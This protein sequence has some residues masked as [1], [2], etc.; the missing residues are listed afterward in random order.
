MADL[1]GSQ[2]TRHAL[3][4]RV[5]EFSQ[6]GGIMP[7]VHDAGRSRGVR[8]L[9]VR[10]GTGFECE[11]V[12]DRALDVCD[13]S[14]R[15]I[16]LAWH[17]PGGL[18]APSYD[19]APSSNFAR[20]FFGGLMTTCGLTAFG[21]AG[22]DADGAWGQHGYID[23]AP[24]E[25]VS[26][27]ASWDGDRCTLEITGT[28][29]ETQLFGPYLRLDRTWRIELGGNVLQLQDRVTNEGGRRVPHMLLY[30]CN[31]G[32]PIV[33]PDTVVQIAQ[34]SMRARDDRA[35]RGLAVWDRGGEPEAQFAEQVFIHDPLPNE[36]GW[37]YA[38]I[39]NPS[40]GKNGM[41]FEVR[42]RP[43]DL[44][45]VFSWRMLAEK[46]YV[47]AVEPANC[48]TIEGR[49]AARDRGTLPFLEP[50][51]SRSYELRFAVIGDG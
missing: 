29:R 34:R 22:S 18:A 3:E 4:Q 1:F 43:D 39:V 41:G 45:A 37:A 25:N 7:F 9:L 44:P 46:T 14:Y 32:F 28:L 33:G 24:A 48:P 38:R 20:N 36:E 2:F 50:G 10:T 27:R 12:V 19:D 31:A 13:A 51:E 8:S 17:A 11:I 47:M 26:Y 5:G 35:A 6:L 16:P 23:H 49:I 15:G 21:P 40:L 30:H 42:F